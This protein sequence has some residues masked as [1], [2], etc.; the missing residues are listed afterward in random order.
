[1]D[2]KTIVISGIT[3][4]IGVFLA[5]LLCQKGYNIT[6][7][8]RNLDKVKDVLLHP[9]IHLIK[10]DLNDREVI[11]EITKDATYIF[12]LAALSKPWG[13]YEDFCRINIRGTKSL[14]DAAP[15][16]LKRFI[17][18]STPSI[19]FNYQDRLNIEEKSALPNKSVNFYAMTKRLAEEVVLESK[20]PSII[21]RPRAIFGPY[22]TTLFP[23]LLNV[24]QT[25][26]L[27]FFKKNSPIID[28][29]YVENVAHALW[30]SMIA[31]D[32]CL[33]EAYNITNCEPCSFVE[34]VEDLLEKLSITAK[35]KYIPYPL[36]YALAYFLELKSK[37]T[38]QEPLLT[39]YTIGVMSFDQTLSVKKAQEELN[40][41]PPISLKTGIDRYVS[42]LKNQ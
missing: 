40:Y 10:A 6:G 2:N 19:Y 38:H 18:V 20:I 11:Q 36:A 24:C 27:P 4:S 7:F 41:Y 23:R 26:G 17:H 9:R 31:P 33:Y 29:T 1:M 32:S 25:K 28:V 30:L 42:W 21:I 16:N 14:V 22:D 13:K 39:R 15:S 5:K 34:L 35:R 37:I 12:H 3:S 8:A